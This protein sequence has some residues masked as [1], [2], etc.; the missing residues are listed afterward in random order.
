M[1]TIIINIIKIIIIIIIIKDLYG[2]LSKSLKI[3]LKRAN[4]TTTPNTFRGTVP[5]FKSKYRKSSITI[6]LFQGEMID[7]VKDP[8]LMTSIAL[9]EHICEVNCEYNKG[10]KH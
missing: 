5:Q 8:W 6:R 1:I 10:P 3:G 7:L 9:W 2:A 4:A